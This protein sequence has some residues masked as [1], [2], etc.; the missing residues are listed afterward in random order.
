MEQQTVSVAKAGIVCNLNAKVSIL[1]TANPIGSKYDPN[2]TIIE[3]INLPATLTSRF[4]LVYLMLDKH[5]DSTDQ[6]LARH[7]ISMFS[8]R[9][10]SGEVKAPIERSVFRAYEY[11]PRVR[12]SID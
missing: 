11:I 10:G 7:I 8:Q 4:D 5:D 6:R 9:E 3:N 1:A 12:R 2:K